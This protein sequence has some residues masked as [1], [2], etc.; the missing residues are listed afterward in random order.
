[1][2]KPTTKTELATRP[3]LKRAL[4]LGAILLALFVAGGAFASSAQASDKPGASCPTSGQK[5]DPNTIDSV[6]TIKAISGSTITIQ[7]AKSGANVT[8]TVNA[9]THVVSKIMRTDN[10]SLSNLHVGNAIAFSGTKSSNS[11]VAASDIVI[12]PNEALQP[13]DSGKQGDSSGDLAKKKAAQ[14]T[15]SGKQGNSSDDAKKAAALAT[16]KK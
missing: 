16:C 9:S 11:S 1:M 12:I 3:R 6:G 4:L 15:D 8:L 5:P 7:D 14:A 10:L 2:E 13:T